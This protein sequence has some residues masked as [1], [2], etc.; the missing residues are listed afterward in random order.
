MTRRKPGILPFVFSTTSVLQTS[1]LSSR[2]LVPTW[3]DFAIICSHLIFHQ[4]TSSTIPNIAAHVLCQ[5]LWTMAAEVV[6]R[7]EGPSPKSLISDKNFKPQNTLF[8]RDI[9][10]KALFESLDKKS[11][12]FFVKNNVSWTRSA[13]LHIA[14]HIELNFQICNYVQK[15]RICR[16]NSKYALGDSFYGHFCHRRKAANFCHPA[17][18]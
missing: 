9:K 6:R 10:I 17:L 1:H 13:L 11:V 14:F 3:I 5:S 4:H 18:D 7:H 16:K 2:T 15:R 8:C 12:F